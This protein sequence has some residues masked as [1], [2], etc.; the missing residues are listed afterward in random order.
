[1]NC[2]LGKSVRG[3]AKSSGKRKSTKSAKRIKREKDRSELYPPG[4]YIERGSLAF[5]TDDRRLPSFTEVVEQNL[6]DTIWGR[7]HSYPVWKQVENFEQVHEFEFD[8]DLLP[9]N[10]CPF[11]KRLMDMSLPAKDV[12]LINEPLK[13][14]PTNRRTKPSIIEDNGLIGMLD[15]SVKAA[16]TFR[17]AVP[18]APKFLPSVSCCL[19]SDDWSFGD[20]CLSWEAFMRRGVKRHDIPLLVQ[21][22]CI[23]QRQTL[24]NLVAAHAYNRDLLLLEGLKRSARM[25]RLEWDKSISMGSVRRVNMS[26]INNLEV[27]QLSTYLEILKMMRFKDAHFVDKELFGW[28]VGRANKKNKAKCPVVQYLRSRIT[29]QPSICRPLRMVSALPPDVL[30]V[31]IWPN[32]HLAGT[33]PV[34]APENCKTFLKRLFPTIAKVKHVIPSPIDSNC[35]WNMYYVLFIENVFQKLEELFAINSTRR[36]VLIGWGLSCIPI[37]HAVTKYDCICATVLMDYRNLTPAGVYWRNH[38]KLNGLNKPMLYVVGDRSKYC[39][40][41]RLIDIQVELKKTRMGFVIVCN[42]IENLSVLPNALFALNAS[43]ASVNHCILEA[44]REFLQIVLH[45]VPVNPSFHLRIP[46]FKVGQ[47]K[48]RAVKEKMEKLAQMQR[49][50]MVPSSWRSP[51]AKSKTKVSVEATEPEDQQQPGTCPEEAPLL[52]TRTRAVKQPLKF[53]L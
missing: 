37:I 14:P 33:K 9:K 17:R 20:S 3:E 53:D 11:Y 27:H 50:S 39:N 7:L 29:I 32:V 43:Q 6:C 35:R 1:M 4:L 26:L 52:T 2:P 28:N 45:Q 24:F 13:W 19:N 23:I 36:I 25:M 41:N 15:L 47:L 5:L 22:H 34:E 46:S 48:S 30:L 31:V 10:S 18:V 38:E 21:C 42:T 16:Y 51:T 40:I 8:K 12:N 49:Y 44:I